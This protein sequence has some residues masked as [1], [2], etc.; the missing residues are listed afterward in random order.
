MI[1]VSSSAH[2]RIKDQIDPT[3]LDHSKILEEKLGLKPGDPMEVGHTIV[4]A[5]TKLLQVFFT[6]EMQVRL[7]TGSYKGKQI[8]VHAY[9]P[10][11]Q[12]LISVCPTRSKSIV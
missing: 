2:Y 9:H 8:T 7:D 4:Y 12:F 3:D 1:N 10:G 6:R 11:M 5:R